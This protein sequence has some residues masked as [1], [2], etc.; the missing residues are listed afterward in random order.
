MRE[1]RGEESVIKLL[2]SGDRGSVCCYS[3]DAANV[4]CFI[5]IRDKTKVSM[6]RA[7][8]V[9]LDDLHAS[10]AIAAGASQLI[11]GATISPRSS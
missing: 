5:I 4:S 8:G 9:P 1:S 11:R 7:Y 10:S 3:H 2:L 6:R